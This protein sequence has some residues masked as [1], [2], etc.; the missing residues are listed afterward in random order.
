MN[1]FSV[2]PVGEYKLP[3]E[4]EIGSKPSL[5]EMQNLVAVQRKRPLMK[6]S[7]RANPVL[8]FLFFYF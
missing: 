1:F 5:A 2:G 6:D 8:N 7:W 4:E 3:F